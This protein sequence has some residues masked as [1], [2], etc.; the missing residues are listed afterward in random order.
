M[1]GLTR[2]S[3]TNFQ[4]LYIMNSDS[5]TT[6]N[7]GPPRWMLSFADLLSVIL[8]FFVL[9]YSM[10]KPPD[11]HIPNAGDARTSKAP[12]SVTRHNSSSQIGLS[13]TDQD[14]STNYLYD[15]IKE[16]VAMHNE[17]AKMQ[18]ISEADRLVIST[19]NE[20]FDDNVAIHMATIIKGMSNRVEIYSDNIDH[21][22]SIL[23]ML[24][25]NGMDKNI[26]FF[27]SND[28]QGKIDIVVY[29]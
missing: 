18:I 11:H 19:K 23:K 5:Q 29:P 13:S 26:N 28:S 20:D 27:A 9:I 8:S 24:Q 12:F 10:S 7:T 1:W 6:I 3:R 4:L 15:I 14:L 16:K 22:Y 17:Q 25:Q 21:S 2:P